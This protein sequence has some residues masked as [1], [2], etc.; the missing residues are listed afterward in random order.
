MQ[1]CVV[2]VCV[3]V[4]VCVCVVNVTVDS[5]EAVNMVMGT[6]L[7]VPKWICLTIINK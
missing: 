3:C 7:L 4:F 6:K 5:E 2:Y 1:V